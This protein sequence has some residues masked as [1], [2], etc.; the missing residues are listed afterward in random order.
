METRA[1]WITETNAMAY[2]AAQHIPKRGVSEELP[3]DAVAWKFLYWRDGGDGRALLIV[4]GRRLIDHEALFTAAR[5][6][7]SPPPPEIRPDAAGDVDQRGFIL[8]WSSSHFWVFTPDDLLSP[9]VQ[10][11]GVHV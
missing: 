10:L 2:E 4:C 7:L 11:L 8:T 5:R 9:M 3:W 6:V 1:F